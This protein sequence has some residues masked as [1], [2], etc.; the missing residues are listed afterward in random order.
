MDHFKK[1]LQIL[2]A[3]EAIK[4]RPK[5]DLFQTGWTFSL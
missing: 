3:D 1:V 4:M 5:F 2:A